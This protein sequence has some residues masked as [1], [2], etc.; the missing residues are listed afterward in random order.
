MQAL[1]L[2]ALQNQRTTYLDTSSSCWLLVYVCMRMCPPL[3]LLLQ[4]DTRCCSVQLPPWPLRVLR[5]SQLDAQRLDAELHT[6][7]QEQFMA[8]LQLF[9]PVRATNKQQQ[10]YQYT[11]IIALN[12]LK[13]AISSSLLQKVMLGTGRWLGC[14]CVAAC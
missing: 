4:H 5:S 7:L 6:M 12:A 9:Q 1:H 10:V 2:L 11:H 3:L 14:T 13:K 8:A